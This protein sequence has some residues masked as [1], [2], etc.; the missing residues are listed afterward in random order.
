M[1]RGC[2]AS[3]AI[4]GDTKVL[5]LSNRSRMGSL[6]PS[7]SAQI[8]LQTGGRAIN[9]RVKAVE[10]Y[11]FHRSARGSVLTKMPSGL[12]QWT[13]ITIGQGHQPAHTHI[14]R[15]SDAGTAQ[16]GENPSG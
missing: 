2:V 4:A 15:P 5:N 6:V 8:H 11:S 7:H 9:T 16:A 1:L 14:C 10:W 12:E 3:V 13:F